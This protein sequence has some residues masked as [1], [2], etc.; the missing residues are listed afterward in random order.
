MVLKY[1]FYLS[2]V[3]S[4]SLHLFTSIN[5]LAFRWVNLRETIYLSSENSNL[6]YYERKKIMKFRCTVRSNHW[7]SIDFSG[8]L[9]IY[10]SGSESSCFVVRLTQWNT[11]HTSNYILTLHKRNI[12]T[13]E[14]II[15]QKNAKI[16]ELKIQ[17]E[18]SGSERGFFCIVTLYI[19]A[20]NYVLYPKSILVI[21][22]CDWPII[23]SVCW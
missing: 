11:T 12:F 8:A 7:S 23:I 6:V 14:F 16:S 13:E 10:R 3:N 1:E 22:R 19:I 20:E 4:Y 15:M 2:I 21:D 17:P 18:Q 9:L 5:N